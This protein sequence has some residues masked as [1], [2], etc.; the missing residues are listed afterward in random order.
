MAAGELGGRAALV[1]GATSG[2]GA[3]VARTLCRAGAAAMLTGRNAERGAAVLADIGSAAGGQARFLAGDVTQR[4]FCERLVGETVR[5]FG[6][7]DIL[8]NAAGV[9]IRA[10]AGETSD[11]EWS[12]VMAVN[13]DAVFRLSR[14]AI[15]AMRRQGGGAIVNVASEWGLVAGQRAVA[16]CTSKGAVVQMTRAM[17]LDHARDGIRVNAI[18][19]GAVETPMLDVEY[20]AL[21]ISGVEGRRRSCEGTPL[22]RIA[23]PEE[24]ARC[25][26]FLVSDAAAFM[27]GSMLTVDGGGTAT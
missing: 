5:E 12:R 13:V 27:T 25:V 22:G 4:D 19:P 21:G 14:A 26:L 6:R 9:I 11:A 1:T 3:A 7:L 24:I 16:Y 20:A 23:T 10:D 8:V 17:A 15:G 2:I 18:C